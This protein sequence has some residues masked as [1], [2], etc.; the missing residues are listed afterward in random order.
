[1]PNY[2]IYDKGLQQL[3]DD[4]ETSIDEN[5]LSKIISAEVYL[6]IKNNFNI[7]KG[8]FILDT[9]SIKALKSFTNK[10]NEGVT[11]NENYKKSVLNFLTKVKLLG[12]YQEKFFNKNGQQITK[13][14]VSVGQQIVIDELIEQYTQNGLNENLIEPVKKMLRRSILGKGT[15]EVFSKSVKKMIPE[16]LQR[17]NSTTVKAGIDGYQ[18]VINKKL[19]EK[20]ADKTTHIRVTNTIINTTSKQCRMCIEDYNREV[21]IKEFDKIFE[22]AKE[23][24]LIEGTNLKNLSINKLHFGCRHQ[25]YPIIKVN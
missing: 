13:N 9:D 12:D 16:N 11:S 5:E 2:D 18:S 10:I 3:I 8:A 19:Y 4:V 15:Y 14:E 24:G 21:P 17:F 1:M 6:F 20:F 25:F 7:S 22:V 23:N